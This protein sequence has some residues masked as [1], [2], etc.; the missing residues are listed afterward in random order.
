M[1]RI[2]PATQLVIDGFACQWNN[3]KKKLPKDHQQI[4]NQ[5]MV[6][7]KKHPHSGPEGIPFQQIIISI[8]IEQEKEIIK[9]RNKLTPKSKK[10]CPRCY[11]DYNKEDFDGALCPDCKEYLLFSFPIVS[12][13]EFLF[14]ML[15]PFFIFLEDLLP[16]VLPH[17]LFVP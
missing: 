8:L 5:L 1:T 4:F 13:N 11:T 9:L 10:Q 15:N 17:M 3:F 7:A 16:L 14:Y 12:K 6:Y 2:I